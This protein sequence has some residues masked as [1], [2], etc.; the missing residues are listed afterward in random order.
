MPSIDAKTAVVAGRT[1]RLATNSAAFAALLAPGNRND[2]IVITYGGKAGDLPTDAIT[3]AILTGFLQEHAAGEEVNSVN[4]RTM[5]STLGINVEEVKS[6]EQT[7][8]NEWL[9]VAAWS[10]DTKVSL[11]GTFF[12]AKND[13]RIVRLNGSP[14]EAT[15][16]G[17][18]LPRENNDVPGI[19]GKVGS[20]L[21]QHKVN[22][23]SMSSRATSRAAAR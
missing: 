3:R 18:T 7:D 15:P 13:P 8:F 2:C 12:G 10:G 21:G 11:G 6:T 4:V 19:V 5:A 20:I 16:S 14:V 17:G 23:A 22:I 9:H 1:S